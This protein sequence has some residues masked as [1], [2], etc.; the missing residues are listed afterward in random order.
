MLAQLIHFSGCRDGFTS[1]GFSHGG[2]FTTALVEAWDG[3]AFGGNYEDLLAAIAAKLPKSQQEPQFNKYGPVTNEFLA[4]RPFAGLAR[5]D[6]AAA[7]VYPLFPRAAGS[8]LCPENQRLLIEAYLKLLDTINGTSVSGCDDGMR[9]SR[10]LFGGSRHLVCVHGISKQDRNYSDG[11]WKA[12][13]TY[14]SGVFGEGELGKTRRQVF[15]SH[16]VNDDSARSA[17]PANVA[18]LRAEIEAVLEDRAVH[19]DD[20]PAAGAGDKDAGT[21]RYNFRVDDFLRYM[22]FESTRKKI[23]ETF[24]SVV[25]PLLA[26]GAVID[27]ISHSWGTVVAYEGLRELESDHSLTNGRIA[28]WFT[29]GSA[30]SMMP[31]Y[32]SLRSENK[33]GRRPSMVRRWINVDARGDLVGGTLRPRFAVD[34]EHLAMYP[35]KGSLLNAH[36]S[37]FTEGNLA[38]N[39]DVFAAYINTPLTGDPF[40]ARL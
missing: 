9:H 24:T 5:V 33:D 16:L 40:C 12:L 8:A 26:D 19:Q 7:V 31:V 22:L 2:A 3:G 20:V 30:L 21:R 6:A 27:I 15:W 29:V 36:L 25:R 10:D 11:W 13:K 34:V 38:V 1:T 4:E 14:V 23:I 18:K 37:Y 39:R 17:E 28:N 35:F 32:H